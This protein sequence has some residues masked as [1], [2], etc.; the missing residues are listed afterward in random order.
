[1]SLCKNLESINI[2][3]S[4]S[5]GWN[6]K[7]ILQENNKW[8]NILVGY[9]VHFIAN[10]FTN[11]KQRKLKENENRIWIKTREHYLSLVA[12]KIFQWKKNQKK[13]K[14]KHI[15]IKWNSFS[16]HKDK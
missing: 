3:S 2:F 8:S 10:I 9:L 16:I 14:K 5:F 4:N 1:M 15:A 12:E 13:T 11:Y 6:E 7:K